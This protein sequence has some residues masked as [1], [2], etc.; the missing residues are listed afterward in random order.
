MSIRLGSFIEA[1]AAQISNEAGRVPAAPK[2]ATLT[3]KRAAAV[4][5]VQRQSSRLF[6]PMGARPALCASNAAA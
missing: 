3:V 1:A 4:A 2:A 5:P 6:V